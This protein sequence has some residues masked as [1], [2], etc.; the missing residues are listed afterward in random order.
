MQSLVLTPEP[1]HGCAKH[2]G[3]QQAQIVGARLI[4]QFGAL[5]SLVANF[6]DLIRSITPING[7]DVRHAR[8][9][10]AATLVRIDCGNLSLVEPEDSVVVVSESRSSL[11]VLPYLFCAL[12]LP[13]VWGAHN[14]DDLLFVVSNIDKR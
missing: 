3:H 4:N 12:D 13:V 6:N 11:T 10:G 1:R 2:G 5:W 7:F 9:S 14:V 8:G